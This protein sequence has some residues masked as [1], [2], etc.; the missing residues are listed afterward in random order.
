MSQTKTEWAIRYETEGGN[1]FWLPMPDEATARTSLKTPTPRT[2]QQITGAD[3]I[4]TRTLIYR[5]IGPW[6][7]APAPTPAA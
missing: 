4:R 3:P 1:T 2:D 7:A 6:T 5:E